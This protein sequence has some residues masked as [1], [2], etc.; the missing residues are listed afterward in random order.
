[1]LIQPMP[2]RSLDITTDDLED[3]V[4]S[5]NTAPEQPAGSQGLDH[6]HLSQIEGTHPLLRGTEL[7]ID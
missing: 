6:S 7:A 3:L 5:P 1:M 4:I 2:R